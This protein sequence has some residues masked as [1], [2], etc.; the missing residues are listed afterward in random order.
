MS[1]R[2]LH[3]NVWQIDIRIGR[4]DRFRKN[5][6]ASSKLQAVLIEQE[7]RKQL[8]RS[9]GDVHSI[10]FIAPQYLE[11][12]KN[13]QSPRTYK[14]KFRMLYA[15]ILP[16]FG[17]FMPDYVTK[18]MIEE[19]KKKRLKEH[20]GI[21]RETNLEILCLNSLVRWAADQ[22]M[23]NNPLPKS[24]PL[25]YRRP[26]P[27]YIRKEELMAIID[28][29]SLKHR[30]LFLCLYQAGLR[31][32]EACNLEPQDI[33]FNPDYIKA[34][35][36]GGKVRLVAMSDLLANDMNTY[37]KGHRGGHLFPSRVRG[38]IITDIRTPLKTAMKKVGIERR[39]TPHCLRHSFATHMLEDGADLRTIQVAMG[40][41]DIGT[42]QIYTKV[43][44]G[45]MTNAIKKC[46]R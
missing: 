10:N 33:H 38:G 30:I 29:M 4:K 6:R 12:V 45:H 20:P 7:Y 35:G 8:G 19:Y 40:H 16:F 41:E 37:L 9:I 14:E 31:K 3:D 26:V 21:N 5:I 25:P 15:Q 39:I 42:T 18:L 46:W 27:E 28:S 36:K 32:S 17:N 11:H 24:K 23:C 34:M 22:G 43:N 13:H 44:L 1:V 2:N